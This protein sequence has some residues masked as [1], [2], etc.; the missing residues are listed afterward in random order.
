M[1]ITAG[2]DAGAK[3][4]KV[5]IL[6]EDEI[7]G[8]GTNPT[9]FD[10][11]DAVE[12]AFVMALEEAGITREQVDRIVATGAGRK[13]VHLAQGNV[14]EV[15]ADARGANRLMPSARTVIDVGAEEGRGISVDERGVLVDSAVNE[16]CAAGAGAFTEAM[17]RALE[18][19][20]EDI[21][22]LSLQST[23]SIDM[24]AQCTVFAESELVTL[25][26][27][28]T[29]TA[30]IARSVHDAI[31]SRITSMVR[32]VGLE[33][34][35]MLIGGVGYNVGFKKSLEED[36]GM[37]VTVP[38]YPEYVTALGAAIIAKEQLGGA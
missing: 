15:T 22:E 23:K 35:V 30:D 17:A 36:L 12:K 21:G 29:A 38:E 16:K 5:I 18:I 20:L 28:N 3:N 11:S 2:I 1:A 31:S 37:G 7:V 19:P 8:R 4:T 9:G 33:P 34:D 25:V 24:N 14:T 27:S 26:H 32:R 6:R 10:Q 13:A